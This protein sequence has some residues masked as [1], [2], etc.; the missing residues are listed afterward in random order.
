MHTVRNKE[1]DAFGSDAVKKKNARDGICGK[2]KACFDF[3]PQTEVMMEQ[4][5]QRS[6]F[7]ST[8]SFSSEPWVSRRMTRRQRR[9]RPDHVFVFYR[10]TR[11]KLEVILR[12]PT[13]Q[14]PFP[15][16]LLSYHTPTYMYVWHVVSDDTSCHKK[17]PPTNLDLLLTI[18]FFSKL[19]YPDHQLS[20]FINTYIF[21][22]LCH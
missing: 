18:P 17:K 10:Q 15:T 8:T 2:K 20:S 12:G 13:E 4:T 19:L 1:P 16:F 9:H 21:S 3:G 7:L 14:T 11:P 5:R 22:R 6:V